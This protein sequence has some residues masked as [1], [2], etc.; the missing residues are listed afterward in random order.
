M[1]FDPQWEQRKKKISDHFNNQEG[2]NSKGGS[3]SGSTSYY[4][5]YSGLFPK[6]NSIDLE[7]IDD[8]NIYYYNYY[9]PEKT[10]NTEIKMKCKLI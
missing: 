7:Y 9:K 3:S 2:Q 8:T 10:L 4:K 5:L 6:K 1:Y